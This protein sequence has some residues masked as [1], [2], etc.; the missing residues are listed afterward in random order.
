MSSQMQIMKTLLS[1]FL[2]IGLSNPALAEADQPIKKSKSSICH[3][4][5]T[6]H[7]SKTKNFKVYD[8][9]EACLASGGRLPKGQTLNLP[10]TPARSSVTSDDQTTKYSRSQFGSGW[11]DADRD[12]QNTR[13]EVLISM[14]TNTV[15]FADD[16]Q[17]RVTFGRWIS[18]YSGNVIFD[19]SQV[20]ID[21][22]V[23]LK[24]A[25][26]HGAKSWG[27]SKR[28]QFANDPINLVAVEASLNRQKGAKGLD[29]WLP[30]KNQE[31]YKARF[32]RVLTKYDLER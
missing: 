26:E 16:K 31:Q 12:C 3:R 29:E 24:W 6:E 28:E 5:N 9:I 18:M 10:R 8:T 1:A 30:P 13:Q 21:H 23:P 32:M 2:L 27:K 22:V 14:S 4:P 7:Y 17:C 25:W 15:R 20:D 19:A 11:D